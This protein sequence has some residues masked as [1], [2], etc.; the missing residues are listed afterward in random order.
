MRLLRT[1][2]AASAAF[3]LLAAPA[4]MAKTRTVGST[5]SDPNMNICFSMQ[6]CTYVNYSGNKPVD[7]VRHAGA[8]VDWSVGADSIGG[9]VQLRILRPVGHGN[10]K[11]VASSPLET[12]NMSGVNKFRVHINVKRGD[13]LALTNDSSGL[14]MSTAA[15][16]QSVHY[17]DADAPLAD[18]ATGQPNRVASGLQVQLSADVRS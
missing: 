14:Y 10:F 13:V 17:F 8:I 6:S 16:G 2:T 9:Q 15:A 3:A 4:A 5:G 7:V 18:G 1:L 12:V 11:A